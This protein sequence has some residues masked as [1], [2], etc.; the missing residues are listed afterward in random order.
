MLQHSDFVCTADNVTYVVYLHVVCRLLRFKVFDN[1]VTATEA[2]YAIPASA[3]PA[4]EHSNGSTT[5]CC[6]PKLRVRLRVRVCGIVVC[7]CFYYY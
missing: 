1:D 6:S 2:T 7:V 4:D 3:D 5:I